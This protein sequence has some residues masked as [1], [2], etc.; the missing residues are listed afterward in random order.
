M[1]ARLGVLVVDDDPDLRAFMAAALEDSGYEVRNADDGGA[2]LML[3]REWRPDLILLD[4]M[5]PRLD[6][7][8]FRQ[9]QL[10]QESLAAIPVVVM[11]AGYGAPDEAAKLAIAAGL[12]KPFDL[13]ELLATVAALTD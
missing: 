3:L 8:A 7:W 2:A 1:A 11:S 10:A 9:A 4:L 6:G 5:T 12:D 13:D